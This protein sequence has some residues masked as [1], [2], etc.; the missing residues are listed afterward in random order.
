MIKAAICHDRS[1]QILTSDAEAP[2]F[3]HS[4]NSNTRRNIPEGARNAKSLYKND[5]HVVLHPKRNKTAV[6]SVDPKE[7]IGTL[8]TSTADCKHVPS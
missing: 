3:K 1:L 8:P 4:I 7:I 2:L 5:K 6:L